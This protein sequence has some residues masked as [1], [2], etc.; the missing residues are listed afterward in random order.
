MCAVSADSEL[1]IWLRKE[2]EQ[3]SDCKLHIEK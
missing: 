3:L 1:V 2:D